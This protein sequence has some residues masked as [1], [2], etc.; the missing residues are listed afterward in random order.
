M[1][2]RAVHHALLG[3]CA[4][5]AVAAVAV[6]GVPAVAD[7]PNGNDS[8][9]AGSGVQEAEW[10]ASSRSVSLTAHP[11]SSLDPDHCMDAMLDWKHTAGPHHDSRVVRSCR[12]GFV[13]HSYTWDGAQAAGVADLNL[14]QFVWIEPLS[15]WNSAGISESQKG[16]GYELDDDYVDDTF[17]IYDEEEF[18][19]AGSPNYDTV[20]RTCTDRWAR[21]LTLYQD[22]H[23]TGCKNYPANSAT[24]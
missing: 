21:V 22:A 16:Y 11:F 17:E 19:G 3:F 18:A 4:S 7:S 5:A 10:H 20:P 8:T 6:V 1:H 14:T 12:A 9:S 2:A 15:F 23:Y 13:N 24:S